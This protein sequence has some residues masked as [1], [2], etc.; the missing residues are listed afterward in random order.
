M[1]LLVFPPPLLLALVELAVVS[2][3]GVCVRILGAEPGL[4]APTATPS[5]PGAMLK[6]LAPGWAG[7]CAVIAVLLKLE[8]KVPRFLTPRSFVF[9]WKLGEMPR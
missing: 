4:P 1:L 6:P 2:A 3:L 8:F 9:A 7:G 5:E